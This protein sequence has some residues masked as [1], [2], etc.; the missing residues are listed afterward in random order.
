MQ[1]SHQDPSTILS[2]VSV[3]GAGT[4]ANVKDYR[5]IM[6]EV[7]MVGFT[8]TINFGGSFKQGSAPD[9]ASAKSLTNAWDTIQIKDL[10]N[11]AGIDG[12]TGITGSAT[13]DVRLLEINT[14]ALTWVNAVLSSVSAGSI[15]VKIIPFND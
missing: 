14:N 7:V 6:A 11:N 15:T 2:A 12:D 5:H 4:P 1:R 13:T 9:I 10:Q 3:D 8:G